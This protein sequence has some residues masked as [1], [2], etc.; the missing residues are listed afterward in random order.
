MTN[1]KFKIGDRIEEDLKNIRFEDG[2]KTDYYYDSSV[3][4]LSK[5]ELRRNKIKSKA[6]DIKEGLDYTK[7]WFNGIFCGAFI[8]SFMIGMVYIILIFE[9]SV[10]QRNAEIERVYFYLNL[11]FVFILIVFQIVKRIA[12]RIVNKLEKA[13]GLL[14]S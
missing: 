10:M 6:E 2:Y 3:K 12:L 11:I 5:K 14:N 9:E 8:F 4:K 13:Y 7:Q 1:K